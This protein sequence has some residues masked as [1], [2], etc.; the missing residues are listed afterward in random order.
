M[1]FTQKIY[2]STISLH[3]KLANPINLGYDTTQNQVIEKL[4]PIYFMK[5]TK[6]EVPL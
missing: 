5:Q 1:K 6:K 2:F 4:L 3:E